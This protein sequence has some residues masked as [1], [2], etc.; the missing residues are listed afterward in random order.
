MSRCDAGAPLVK[1]VDRLPDVAASDADIVEHAVV[2]AVEQFGRG[3]AALPMADRLE[4]VFHG[5]GFLL[6]KHGLI[7]SGELGAAP[8][9]QQEMIDR[10]IGVGRIRLIGALRSLR[11][12][13][14]S[15]K[16]HFMASSVR[17]AVSVALQHMLAFPGAKQ[18]PRLHIRYAMGSCLGLGYVL[19]FWFRQRG[20]G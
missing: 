18:W 9:E 8:A 16:Q 7:K 1:D 13:E 10:R 5:Y 14:H 2:Q 20:G 3:V 19:I 12:E 4:D 17:V 11:F 15:E 6:I